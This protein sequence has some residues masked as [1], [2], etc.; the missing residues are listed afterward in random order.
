VK[1]ARRADQ[2][3]ALAVVFLLG[4]PGPLRGQD[5]TLVVPDSVALPQDTSLVLPDSAM[6]PLDSLAQG[7]DTSVANAEGEAGQA[8][9][10]PVPD[11]EVPPGPMVPGSRYTFTPDSLNWLS[12]VTLA[13]LLTSI[14]GVY[15]ARTGFLGQPEFVMYA[16][17]G[18]GSLELYWDGVLLEPLGRDSLFHDPGRVNLTYLERV[19]V[20][21]LPSTL[22]V[23]LVS[24]RHADSTPLSSIRFM[25]GDFSTGGYAGLFQKRFPG[26][27]S[28]NLAA[29]FVGTEGATGTGRTDQTFDAW[30][31]IDWIPSEKFGASYQLRSQNHKRD[32]IGSAPLFDVAG[33]FG[34][35]TDQMF[36]IRS[37]SRPGGLGLGA[38][39]GVVSSVWSSDTVDQL[40]PDQTVRQA[41]M[42]LRYRTPN[43]TLGLRGRIGDARIESQLSGRFGWVPLPGIVLE[44]D[45]RWT[46]HDRDRTSLVGNGSVGLYGG[47]FS[48][49]GTMQYGDAV[50]APAITTDSA[51]Q[52]LDKSIR[53]ALRTQ[54]LSGHVGIV[55]RDPY[56]PLPF[57]EVAV[58][59][60]FDTTRETTY[61]V[62]NVRLAS[63]RALALE[64]WY[65]NP[66]E[67]DPGNLQPPSHA[68]IQA[69]FRSK[70]WR[71]FRSGAFDLKVQIS[72]DTWSEGIGGYDS[73]GNPVAL[74]AATFWEGLIQIGL[75]DFSVFGDWRNM[76]NSKETYFPGLEYVRRIVF[77]WGVK[78][79]FSS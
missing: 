24:A 61:L 54:P 31:R 29:D 28:L 9:W 45:A 37:G 41:F 3:A 18:G 38:E 66:L 64:G 58:V 22:R 79:E 70:F 5:T 48:L 76:Y 74:P 12:G 2:A 35:R 30:T 21:V 40:V 42:A 78:W 4:A 56:L 13:D 19:D 16:G 7:Q 72:I 51:Q 39:T 36:Q 20:H 14:P 8:E 69:T 34:T 67:G 27:F 60:R 71:T 59:S 1:C 63:S 10:L 17:R 26:G 11:P 65:S 25:A 50:Q 46:R 57:P 43:M 77:L 75:V 68:R 33:R 32:G 55:W 53:A 52:T 15:V 73:G 23:Y 47:P 62:A 49:V 44:G 6:P